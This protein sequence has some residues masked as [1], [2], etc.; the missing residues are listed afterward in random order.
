MTHSPSRQARSVVS[1]GWSRIDL[2]VDLLELLGLLLRDVQL[3]RQV[4]VVFD[5]LLNRSCAVLQVGRETL[6]LLG[7]LLHDVGDLDAVQSRLSQLLVLTQQVA[8]DV[9]E[10]A[11]VVVEVADHLVGALELLNQ[12]HIFVLVVEP[13]PPHEGPPHTLQV[14]VLAKCDGEL[15]SPD[16]VAEEVLSLE[17][18]GVNRVAHSCQSRL[19]RANQVFIGDDL[20]DELL[21][22]K[23]VQL[24]L[25]IALVVLPLAE[26]DGKRVVHPVE[27]LHRALLRLL[28][29]LHESLQ[30]V[31]CLG[32]AEKV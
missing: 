6:P 30:L 27:R 24:A 28:A 14:V 17:S 8:I 20:I 18:E 26:V 31:E 13:L 32:H 16:E 25:R 23:S 10:L 29:F 5:Q 15:L 11:D 3:Y 21:L 12:A 1:L 19:G 22:G 2:L 9:L 4:I 7:E